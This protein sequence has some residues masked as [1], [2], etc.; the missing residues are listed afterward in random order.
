MSYKNYYFL[1]FLFL[2]AYP[3]FS[4]T[5]QIQGKVT[6]E[7]GNALASSAQILLNTG[8]SQTRLSADASGTF[9]AQVPA[10]HIV[11]YLVS[12]NGYRAHRSHLKLQP[13][14]VYSLNVKLERIGPIAQPQPDRPNTHP[15][16]EMTAQINGKII[17]ETGLPKPQAVV[18]IN[19]GKANLITRTD[20]AGNF[21]LKA[22]ANKIL[23]CVVKTDDYPEKWT[24]LQLQSGQSYS[25]VIQLDKAVIASPKI[26][27]P[28]SQISVTGKVTNKEGLG[29]DGASVAVANTKFGTITDPNGAFHLDV[30]HYK[31]LTFVISSIGYK[32]KRIDVEPQGAATYVLPVQLERD[33]LVLRAVEV[34]ANRSLNKRGQVS[35]TPLQPKNIKTLPSAFGD[36]NKILATL[37]GVVSNNE[38]S[39][40][41]SV[42]GGSFDENLVYVNMIEVYRPFLVRSGQQEG[43]S[44]VNPDLVQNIE[45]SAGGWQP[46]YGDKLS[47]VLT[48]NYKEPTE[49]KGS[50]TAGLLGGAAHLE[51]ATPSQRVS[52]VAG[53]REKR[54]QYLLGTLDVKG[55]YLPRFTDVQS[56]LNF[57]LSKRPAT[58]AEG[59]IA[60]AEKKTTIGVLFSYARNR[61]LTRPVSRQTTFGTLNQIKRLYIGFEGQELM[62]YDMYQGGIKFTHQPTRNLTLHLITSGMQTNERE[63]LDTE[64][65]YRLGDVEIDPSTNKVTEGN[66]VGIGSQY[67]YSRNRLQ[68]RVLSVENRSVWDVNTRHTIEWGMKYGAEQIE[69]VLNEYSFADS[70]DYV[71][72]N[73]TL[74]TKIN[75]NTQRYSGYVQ[76]S[77]SPN[78]NLTVTYGSRFGYWSL[79]KQWLISPSAQFAFRPNWEKEVVFKV[80]SGIYQQPPFYREL[81]NQAGIINNQ[82]KAQRSLHVIAG[83]ERRLLLWGREF[84]LN[85]EIYYKQIQNAITY[86]IENV[87]IRYYANNNAKAYATGADFRLSGEFIK[88]AESWF[89]IGFLNTREDLGFDDR[90]YLRRPTDQRVTFAAFFQDHIPGNPS[91][92]VFLNLIYG[93][94]LSFGPPRQLNYRS[95]FNG[96]SYRR[97]DIGFSKVINFDNS[98]FANSLWIGAEVLNLVGARNTLSYTWITD[99]NRR[100]YAV[101]NTLSARFLNLKVIMNFGGKKAE[102][103]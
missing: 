7:E 27:T 65:A 50:I 34:K 16:I 9:M 81:R 84:Q 103:E 94:G 22:P 6:D 33:S 101:P 2:C 30:P 3:V 96:P 82:L 83:A 58:S 49:T 90:G 60:P 74:F 98:K 23:S 28:A 67:S 40:T 51:T 75:L 42:R 88:G 70:S 17:T 43:L 56:Y 86:D 87:R 93:S 20:A 29:I 21:Q 5:A 25:L 95:A 18:M 78:N 89:S 79:N 37:P 48:I 39:S 99:I 12:A 41:Y 72:I 46:K 38:L 1:V 73:D 92:R 85:S 64:G 24:S 32:T 14:Q 77:F 80:A 53:V 57:D 59:S 91:L 52:L 100:Q 19:T 102:K 69:D 55:E 15:F 62:N 11:S 61:Y 31:S 47:S 26:K 10:N 4:Q 36:F 97:V 44:F 76:H 45:F 66:T 71:K 35:L 63:Y 13:G 54:S 68:A 8:I